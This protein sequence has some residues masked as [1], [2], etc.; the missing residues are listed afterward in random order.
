MR[1]AFGLVFY[2]LFLSATCLVTFSQTPQADAARIYAKAKARASADRVHQEAF[3]DAVALYGKGDY[4]TTVALLDLIIR[5]YP[6][7]ANAYHWRASTYRLWHK[8]DES[9]ADYTAFL[10]LKSGEID[11]IDVP[12]VTEALQARAIFLRDKGRYTEALSDLA[13]SIRLNPRDD[14]AYYIRVKVY[15]LMGLHGKALDDYVRLI[16]MQSEWPRK[17]NR[18]HEHIDEHL[19]SKDYAGALADYARL[20]AALPA[21]FTEDLY[22]ERGRLLLTLGKFDLALADANKGIERSGSAPWAL[23][24]RAAIYE[25]QGKYDLALADYSKSISQLSFSGWEH[26]ARAGIY[27]KMRNYNAAISDYTTAIKDSTT[28]SEYYTLRAKAY[29]ASGSKDRAQADEDKARSLGA[30][31]NNPCN[32]R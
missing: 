27:M 3:K 19:D 5:D 13:R 11:E 32:T 8:P 26:V 16:E 18:N 25:A 23:N 28:N 15:T 17:P 4:A 24:D 14:F 6:K 21:N 10:N 9:M 7:Y 30:K 29:C 31:V 22:M 2:A 1:S 12:D 20:I